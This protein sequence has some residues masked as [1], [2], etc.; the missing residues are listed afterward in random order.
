MS[1]NNLKLF[2][3]IFIV[4]ISSL[5]IVFSNVLYADHISLVDG[6]RFAGKIVRMDKGI[7]VFRVEYASKNKHSE[8]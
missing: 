8:E 3:I 5:T 1:I 7:L 6:D 4:L 2:I